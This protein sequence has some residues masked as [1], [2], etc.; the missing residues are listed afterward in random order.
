MGEVV[1]SVE[2]L[3]KT[4]GDRVAVNNVSFKV[5]AGEVFGFLGP[6]GAGKTTT[7]RMICGLTSITSGN[8]YV[9]GYSVKTEFEKAMMET[10]GI[11]ETP[12]LYGYMSGYDNL[13][14]YA[15]LYK[16]IGNDEIMHYAKVVGLEFRIKDK[17]KKYSLGMRQ[18]LGIAQALLHKPKLLILDEPLSGLDP[19]GVKELRDFLRKIAKQFKIGILISSHMLSDMEQLCDTLA[20]I[21]NGTLMETKSIDQLKKGIE[22]NKKIKIKVDYPNYAGKI[23][24]HKFRMKVD[25]AGSSIIVHGPEEKITD[26]TRA[27]I[28]NKISIFGVEMVTQNL[29]EVFLQIINQNNK[30]QGIVSIL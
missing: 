4:F 27:L 1:L 11:I 8:A 19:N 16:G 24:L 22:S 7:M 25:V 2:N 3:T 13:K 18:R 6:N 26:L 9:C 28:E 21:N 5:H 30:K 17:V 23:I 12:L 29:E 20:I 10:G 15:S 14:Y